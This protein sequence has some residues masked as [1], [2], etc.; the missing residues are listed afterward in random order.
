MND[1][2]APQ[3]P[4]MSVQEVQTTLG[5]SKDLAYRLCKEER[6]RVKKLGRRT[7]VLRKSFDE[8]LNN[9]DTYS[10]IRMG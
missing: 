4:V 2:T 8:W 6:F 10:V 3:R 1:N 7:V 5:I 9:G